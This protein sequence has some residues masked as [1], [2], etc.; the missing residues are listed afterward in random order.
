M[1]QPHAF[2]AWFGLPAALCPWNL[3]GFHG[4]LELLVGCV[5]LATVGLFYFAASPRSAPRGLKS[6]HPNNH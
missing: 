6:N 1:V 5:Y 3:I 2:L 4:L